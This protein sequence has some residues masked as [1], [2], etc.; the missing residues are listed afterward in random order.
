MPFCS[1]DF[2]GLE[3]AVEV[4]KFVAVSPDA[5][6]LAHLDD[7]LKFRVEVLYPP[8]LHSKL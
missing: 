6:R 8:N 2:E 7:V 1:E 3:G 4:R 5:D